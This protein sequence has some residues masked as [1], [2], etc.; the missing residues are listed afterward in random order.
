MKITVLGN[1][2][3]YPG[4]DKACSGYLLESENDTKILI[5][6]GNG[7][8]SRLFK[9]IDIKKIDAIILSHLH[10][11]HIGDMFVFKYAIGINK[12]KG[13]FQGSIP[14]YTPKDDQYIVNNMNYNGAFDIRDID[15]EKVLNI[16]ELKVTFKRTKHPVETYS[17][18]VDNGEKIFVYS[19]DTS[20]F[21]ELID[22]VKNVDLF[23]CEA[24]VLSRDKTDDIPH[25]TPSEAGM[26]AAKAGVKRLI[27]THF[28]PEYKL[29]D[30]MKEA[31]DNYDSI[32]ELSKDMQ[33][34]CL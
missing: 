26:I 3:P 14:V 9:F 6:C 25:L 16:N 29:E 7:V 17:I 19:S 23:L 22:F 33:T 32:L 11:D 2:G 27:L 1:N 10:M 18:K 15:E 13:K 12:S 20:Y 30:I 4:T 24:G 5:D 34:Y 28:W 8:L 21:T 31:T